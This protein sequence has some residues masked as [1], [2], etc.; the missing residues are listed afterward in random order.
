MLNLVFKV[1]SRSLLGLVLNGLTK[2]WTWQREAWHR[3]WDLLILQF[4][5]KKRAQYF[6]NRISS[7]NNLFKSFRCRMH[8]KRCQSAA[9]LQAFRDK[10]IKLLNDMQTQSKRFNHFQS[11]PRA[12]LC[13]LQVRSSRKKWETNSNTSGRIYTEHSLRLMGSKKEPHYLL[14]SRESST[15]IVFIYPKKNSESSTSST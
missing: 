7:A 5:R 3:S 11:S 6:L 13:R 14:I 10:Y 1:R 12:R 9:S 2:C 15:R 4:K 8:L